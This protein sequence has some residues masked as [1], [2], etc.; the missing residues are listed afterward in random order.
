MRQWPY[1]LLLLNFIIACQGIDKRTDIESNDFLEV[2]L[3][4]TIE[5]VFEI[6][7][8]TIYFQSYNGDIYK[9]NMRTRT[10]GWKY[11]NP[12]KSLSTSS[13]IT[14]NHIFFSEF[15]GNPIFAINKY[16]QKVMEINNH[17]FYS[18]GVFIEDKDGIIFTGL[19]G[20]SKININKGIEDW[21]IPCFDKSRVCNLS[22]V[23]CDK[24]IVIAQVGDS[25]SYSNDNIISVQKFNGKINWSYRFEGES[26]SGLAYGK[27]NIYA[28]VKG[29]SIDSEKEIDVP[30]I[31]C[32]DSKSGNLL[33]KK[34]HD[35][36]YGSD[37][38]FNDSSLFYI[39]ED[40]LVS[41]NAN[42]GILN[43]KK[44]LQPLVK[45]CGLYKGKILLK[46]TNGLLL[47]DPLEGSV[48][49]NYNL[50]FNFGPWIFKNEICFSRGNRLYLSKF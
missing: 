25:L 5:N 7:G 38:L 8:D 9:W 3:P 36:L 39:I 31:L 43:W 18:S 34:K 41:V 1:I 19:Y 22:I 35:I 14:K 29:P 10:L 16:G 4:D 17:F 33:W 12:A 30:Y 37:F 49:S 42:T 32:I 40:E 11:D 24:D 23:N 21:R 50:T 48:K 45:I 44:K 20:V 13:L 28:G 27:Q 6:N 15:G 2:S 26:L 47:V 46:T